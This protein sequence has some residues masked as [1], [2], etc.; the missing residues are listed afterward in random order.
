ME[1]DVDVGD[2]DVG[3]SVGILP[4]AAGANVWLGTQNQDGL[5]TTVELN[6]YMV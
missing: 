1:V 2:V 5:S 3:R 4:T 6:A